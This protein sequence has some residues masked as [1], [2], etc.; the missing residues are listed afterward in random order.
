MEE[1][2]QLHNKLP[3]PCMFLHQKLQEAFIIYCECSAS[4]MFYTLRYM[5]LMGLRLI[6]NATVLF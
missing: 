2:K 4:Q 6:R 3:N 1:L 5:M